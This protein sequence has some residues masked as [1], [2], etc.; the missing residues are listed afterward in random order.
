M[1]NSCTRKSEHWAFLRR[2]TLSQIASDL[3]FAI[4][5]FGDRKGTTKKNCVTKT[6]PNVR[7]N[8]L[9]R[10]ASKPLFYWVITGNPLEL[11]RKFFGA[12]RAIFWLW[13]SLGGP[14]RWHAINTNRL[15][16]FS[17]QG[18]PGTKPEPETGTVGTVFAG[19]ERGT[20]TTGTVFQN[21]N[22]N[23]NRPLC[24]TVLKHTKT[25]SLKEPP[26]PKTGT[27]RTVP[28]PNRN[29]TEP[30]RG[31]PVSPGNSLRAKNLG[32][33]SKKDATFLPTIGSF[34]LTIELGQGSKKSIHHHRG[35]LFSV[36]RPTPRSQSTK[37]AILYT[38]VFL[39]KQGKRVY[40][41]GPERRV[42]T[43]EASD[44]EK[45]KQKKQKRRA[46]MVVVYT[47]FFPAK[48]GKP[49]KV[50]RSTF[51]EAKGAS[52]KV[53]FPFN[54]KRKGTF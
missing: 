50:P 42:Y 48:G 22:R 13:G 12:V 2:V 18:G 10:F 4:L 15:D 17:P 53:A 47:F 32:A 16:Y 20:G 14:E 34:L 40:T 31:Q 26:E 30:N 51:L 46:S 9:V 44:P 29:R 38:I 52:K 54:S 19:T 25:L 21:R 33:C 36:C 45:E 49:R 43:I 5:R 24:E 28:S 8:F 35:T 7:V 39:G 41:I 1:P 6:L 11:F 23:R 27:A 3:R 37:K